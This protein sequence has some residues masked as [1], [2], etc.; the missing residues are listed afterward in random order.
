[1]ILYLLSY[2]RGIQKMY[3]EVID[4]VIKEIRYQILTEGRTIGTKFA[5][6]IRNTVHSY[7]SPAIPT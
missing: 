4:S 1:L 3:W 6:I 5:N 7:I 2:V